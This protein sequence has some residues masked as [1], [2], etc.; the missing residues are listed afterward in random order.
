MGVPQTYASQIL[1]DLVKSRLAKSKSGKDGGYSLAKSPDQIKLLDVIEAGEGPLT[2]QRC[3]LGDE[4]C[5]WDSVC[6][7]HEIWSAATLALRKVLENLTLQDPLEKDLALESGDYK[8]PASTHRK[9]HANI[10]V[11]DWIQVEN[12]V[13]ILDEFMKSEAA[14]TE[15]FVQCFKDIDSLRI[16]LDASLPSWKIEKFDCRGETSDKGFYCWSV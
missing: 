6:P 9:V 14:L 4:P 11:S 2:T 12:S 7:L 10:P 5:R 8:V 1:N 15:V 13:F 16:N 3:S